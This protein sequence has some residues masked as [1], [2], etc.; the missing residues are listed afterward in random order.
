MCHEHFLYRVSIFAQFRD[1]LTPA[2]AVDQVRGKLRAKLK[3]PYSYGHLVSNSGQCD[4]SLM[5]LTHCTRCDGA[6]RRRD[7]TTRK[8]NSH[9]TR[10]LIQTDRDFVYRSSDIGVKVFSIQICFFF[11]CIF[12]Y[13]HFLICRR[14]NY[15][16]GFE[17]TILTF[18]P[19]KCRNYTL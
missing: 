11:F 12:I 16:D 1:S 14:Y 19:Y 4:T 6:T 15:V 17:Q 2:T 10:F 7:A 3:I 5:A 8:C 9:C 18:P 13:S